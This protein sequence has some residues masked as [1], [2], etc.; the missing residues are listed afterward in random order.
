MPLKLMNYRVRDVQ[1]GSASAL[2]GGCLELDRAELLARLR[3]YRFETVQ[4]PRTFG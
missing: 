2:H 4:A 3:A 1:F